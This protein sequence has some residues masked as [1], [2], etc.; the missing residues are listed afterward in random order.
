MVRTRP[1]DY[2]TSYP[3]GTGGKQQG[4]EADHLP[5]PGTEV[6]KTWIYRAAPAFIFIALCSLV[7]HKADFAST[8]RV[9]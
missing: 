2:P 5:T 7:E 6:K 1:W 8:F 4:R 3:I 9:P